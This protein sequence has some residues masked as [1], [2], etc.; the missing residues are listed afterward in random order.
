MISPTYNIGK[1]VDVKGSIMYIQML[2]TPNNEIKKVG[3]YALNNHLLGRWQ[4]AD[5]DIQN[6]ILELIDLRK[7]K[8]EI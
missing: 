4:A 3:F 5:E 6:F 2:D 1:I 7:R 8:G